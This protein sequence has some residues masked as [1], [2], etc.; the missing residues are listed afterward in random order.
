MQ[1]RGF[2]LIELVITLVVLAILAVGVTS[3]IGI[4]ASMYS[5]TAQREQLLG[6]SR[7]VAERMLRELRNAAP[8]SIRVQQQAG[9]MSCIEFSPVAAAGFYSVAPI[10]PDNHAKLELNLYNWQAGLL[11]KAFLIY[12][13]NPSDYYATSNAR[14]ELSGA[15]VTN[16]ADITTPAQGATVKLSLNSPHSFE[17]QSPQKRF[18][19]VDPPVSYCAANG[20]I[21]RLVGHNYNTGLPIIGSGVLMAESV[22]RAEFKILPAVLTRNA[23]VNMLLVFGPEGSDLFFNY[24][25]HIPNVP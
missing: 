25:V 21:R 4:G 22:R 3:Y 18:Y 10:K 5:D 2:T 14:I 12:P 13:L 15:V 19:I 23:V 11:N 9:I 20:Q 7:F 8:N 1:N 17:H 6:Q 24:E 16:S